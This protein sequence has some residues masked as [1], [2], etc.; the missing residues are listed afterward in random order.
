MVYVTTVPADADEIPPS[1]EAFVRAEGPHLKGLARLLVG[2][3]GLAEDLLQGVLARCFPRW[4]RIQ[5]GGEPLA[6]V[7]RSLVNART[8][9]WRARRRES[10]TV[11]D[12]VVPSPESAIVDSLDL[13]R[14]VRQ[15]SRRQRQ[16]LALRYS[17]DLPEADIA[18][19]LR[20]NVGT[21]KSQ[22]SRAIA[23]LRTSYASTDSL[24]GGPM[25]ARGKR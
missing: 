7:R 6:Y 13:E 10:A 8:S 17:C 21:V 24:S 18:H 14:R 2:D 5:L 11:A 20:I 22:H 4:D 23:K 25:E 19:L 9:L 12:S 16:V 3:D 15:L 1:F